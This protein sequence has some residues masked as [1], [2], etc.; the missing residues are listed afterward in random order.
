[1]PLHAITGLYGEEG[2]RRRLAIEAQRLDG[3]A[4]RGAVEDALAVASRLHRADARQREPYVNHL[5]RVTIRIISHYRVPDSEVA[6]A[7]LLHDSVEDHAADLSPGGGRD[8]AR[9]VLADR[10][11]TR[12]ADLVDAVTNPAWDP[13]RDEHEQYLEHVTASL[14]ASPWARVVKVSDFTDNGVGLIYTTGPKTVTL[15]RKYAPLAP[16][17]ASLISR[18]DTPLDDD[19]KARILTQLDAA[20]RRFAAITGAASHVP[21]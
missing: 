16:V 21:W 18:P 5:L 10:F 8:G 17:L 6:C 14:E 20:Q 2:L 15:A 9:E 7:A 19:V 12:V 11:G 4:A 3:A 1:M 13:G